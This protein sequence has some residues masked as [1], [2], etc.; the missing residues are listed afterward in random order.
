MINQKENN[1]KEITLMPDEVELVGLDLLVMRKPNAVI[2]F[3]LTNGLEMLPAFA[4]NYKVIRIQSTACEQK[5]WD[6]VL[7]DLD[8]GFLFDLAIG[9]TCYVIDFSQRK[10]KPR[11]L[12]QG[13]EWIQY[14]LNR[15]WFGKQTKALVRGN[16][17]S[18]YFDEVYKTIDPKTIKKIKYFKKFLK[19]KEIDLI[20]VGGKTANDGNYDFYNKLVHVYA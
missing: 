9:K 2:Y 1:I 4:D 15:V 17:A 16:D 11:A 10:Q 3:N 6:F 8:N 19:C 7:S 12:F 14:V 20:P 13:L 18:R 5:R